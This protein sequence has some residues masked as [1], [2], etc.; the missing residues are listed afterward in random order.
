[1]FHIWE[2]LMEKGDFPK[3]FLQGAI[4]QLPLDEPVVI[5]P[6]FR[7]VRKLQALKKPIW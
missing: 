5:L 3:E 2:P 7:L 1:M 4:L 6:L